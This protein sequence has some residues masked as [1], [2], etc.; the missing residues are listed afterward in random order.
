[1]EAPPPQLRSKENSKEIDAFYLHLPG[2]GRLN[3]SSVPFRLWK[4]HYLR[5]G[6]YVELSGQLAFVEMGNGLFPYAT[7]RS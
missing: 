7:N 2:A 4:L 6:M 5:T 1:M 3:N